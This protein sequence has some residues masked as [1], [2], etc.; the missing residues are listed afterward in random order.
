[1][2]RCCCAARVLPRAMDRMPCCT[3]YRRPCQTFWSLLAGTSNP[4]PGHSQVASDS[5]LCSEMLRNA[6]LC[7]GTQRI[8]VL[9]LS[10]CWS[11]LTM[12]H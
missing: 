12:I 9:F 2:L 10:I 5:M 8:S 1:M 3:A 7:N 11:N 4:Q 6:M